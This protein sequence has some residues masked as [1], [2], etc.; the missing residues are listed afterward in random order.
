M[1]YMEMDAENVNQRLAA[2]NYVLVSLAKKAKSAVLKSLNRFC[3]RLI[4][5]FLGFFLLPKLY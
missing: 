2:G 4:S 5:F 1:K 3:F